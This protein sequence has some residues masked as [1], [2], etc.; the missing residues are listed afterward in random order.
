MKLSHGLLGAVIVCGLA[1]GSAWAGSG[2]VPRASVYSGTNARLVIKRAANFG[3]EQHFS[4]YI[5][6]VRVTNLGWGETYR[7]LV[8][9]GEHLVTIQ[10]M[11][12]WNDAYPYS[13]QR[14]RLMPNRTS[15]FTAIWRDGGTRI[16]L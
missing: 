7:G 3:N 2:A 9:A 12:H 13:Q 14:I 1:A 4:L 10:Q 8:P 5:D 15:V 11:P 16:A 6:G